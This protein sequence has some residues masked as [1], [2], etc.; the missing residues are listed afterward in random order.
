MPGELKVC[1]AKLVKLVDDAVGVGAADAKVLGA[2]P[3]PSESES[4]VSSRFVDAFEALRF[5]G[6]AVP[7]QET[8]RLRFADVSADLDRRPT[9]RRRCLVFGNFHICANRRGFSGRLCCD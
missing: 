3:I 8:E 9:G 2:E 6:G 4:F 7:C 1:L 5:G